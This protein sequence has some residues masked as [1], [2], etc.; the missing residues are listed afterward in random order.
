MTGVDLAN[1]S[2]GEPSARARPLRRAR[3]C[4]RVLPKPDNATHVVGS[5][6]F[7][8]RRTVGATLIDELAAYAD[9]LAK[10]NGQLYLTGIGEDV[11]N[12]MVR[13]GKLREADIVSVYTSTPIVGESTRQA[14]ADARMWLVSA[15]DDAPPSEDLHP[16]GDQ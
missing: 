8:G 15:S 4:A 9:Q 16:Q 11:Y 14:A 5:L 10:A 13:T 1:D 6:R 12:Q 2:H 7:R 3:T